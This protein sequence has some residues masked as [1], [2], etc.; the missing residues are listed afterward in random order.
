MGLAPHMNRR[1]ATG[2]I[3]PI[4]TYGADLF[5]P[6]ASSLGEMTVLWNNV[7]RWVTNCFY[8]KAVSICPCK[9]FLPPLDSHLPHKRKMAAF[10]MAC[11]S[12]LINPAAARMPTTL[13]GHSQKEPWIPYVL[14]WLDS[15]SAIYRYS[16][17]NTCLYPLED[18]P[19]PLTQCATS[20]AHW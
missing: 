17:T 3:L 6:H 18:S 11:S 1:L 4:L 8:S 2:L 13:T 16:A 19:Y 15:R 14:C 9:A 5:A 7:L 12:P 20:C 10:R